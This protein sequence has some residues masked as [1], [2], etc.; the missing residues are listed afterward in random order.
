[1][2]GRSFGGERGGGEGS[3]AEAE[4]GGRPLG[5]RSMPQR[6]IHDQN[7]ALGE[8]ATPPADQAGD[9]L[10]TDGVI[11]NVEVQP[12][13]P[14]LRPNDEG[15]DGQASI[16]PV[17]TLMH[18]RWPGGSSFSGRSLSFRH[19]SHIPVGSSRWIDSHSVRRCRA[20][21]PPQTVARAARGGECAVCWARSRG[22]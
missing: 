5:P 13:P 17:P 2:E 9:F 18:R 19:G 21:N 11:V 12:Q 15:G 1:M 6:T 4:P 20:W 16:V 22:P 7:D 10:G 3:V 14:P 8:T